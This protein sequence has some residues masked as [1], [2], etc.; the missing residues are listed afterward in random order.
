MVAPI[1][2][3]KVQFFDN[4]GNSCAGCL[5]LTFSAGTTAPLATYPE[6]T[7]TTPNVTGL[8]S[9]KNLE[10]IRLAADFA[11]G[12]TTCGV[13]EAYD[14]LPSTGGK[15]ILQQGNCSA[16]GWP[17]T[18]QK[19]VVIEGQGM[20]GPSDP[21]TNANIVAGSS[22]TN[23]STGS[24]FF[25]LSL[26]GSSLEGVTF[27][28]FAMIGN[29]AVG[30]ATAGDCVN[31][32]GGTTAQQVRAISFQNLQCNQP[33]GSG[34]V[35]KDNAF[36]INF[37]NVHVDQSGSHC[38]VLKDGISSG[39]NS[40]IHFLQ[41]T[42][43]L[44]GGKNASSNP[45]TADCWNISGSTSRTV[46]I[47]ASTCADSN[48][49]I[50]VVAGAVNTNVHVT[51]SDFETNSTCDISLNDGFGH[52]IQGST[53]LG[54]GVGARG[55][56][57]HFPG[58]AGTTNIQ[59]IMLGNN[60]N[61]HTVRDV[62]IG[63]TQH[64]CLLL[65]QAQNSYSFSDASGICV[66]MDV[67]TDGGFTFNTP[68]GLLPIGGNWTLGNSISEWGNLFLSANVRASQ[69][70]NRSTN[71]PLIFDTAPT[72][73]GFGT[74]PSVIGS[75]G[76]ASFAI[77]VGT[78]GT[79]SNG[80]II[81]PSSTNGWNCWCEDQTTTSA[82]VNRCKQTNGTAT[83]AIIGNFNTAPAAA[84]WLASDILVVSCFAR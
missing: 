54:T 81:L 17:V 63:A 49:G 24:S 11:S 52:Y 43:D 20:G 65:P 2:N 27:K 55:I 75:N 37:L 46:D 7:G 70:V 84:A 74:A 71:H 48:N 51:N 69:Y 6:R 44:C 80:T 15:I 45:G 38:Y 8:T 16:S 57:T 29:K 34:F 32:N 76:T 28:D 64:T 72:V 13:Q 5:L 14:V 79:A 33:K 58:G 82:T 26:S 12:S 50:N 18:I 59:L 60:I 21:G 22:L 78:G 9:L 19:P 56:C 39:V 25:N 41:S 68:G 61:S 77:N 31:V 53:L 66:K 10:S 40:Q 30:G 36:M 3:P 47:I 42:G 62:T 4:A 73:T 83:S 1:T 23:T 35:I 67:N